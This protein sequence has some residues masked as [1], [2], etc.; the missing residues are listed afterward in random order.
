MFVSNEM[1]DTRSQSKLLGFVCLLLTVVLWIVTILEGPTPSSIGAAAAL[2]AIV[3][4][5][6]VITAWD[7]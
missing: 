5:A 7:W 6:V 2:T 3:A 4:L 1:R